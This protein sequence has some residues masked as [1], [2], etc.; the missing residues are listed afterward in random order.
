MRHVD[1][2]IADLTA[3]RKR[4]GLQL[5]FFSS[6]QFSVSLHQ[7]NGSAAITEKV[8]S[9]LRTYNRAA[10]VRHI[11]KSRQM[12][13]MRHGDRFRRPITVLTE[14]QI[15]LATPRIIAFEGI[16]PVQQD[17]HVRILLQ[18]IMQAN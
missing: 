18:R 16:R 2:R 8:Q 7:C 17:D 1:R 4:R 5:L 13:L 15:R 9:K 6:A 12:Q 11:R 14:N 10:S 3:F